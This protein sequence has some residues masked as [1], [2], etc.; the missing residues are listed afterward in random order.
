V[1]G[2]TGLGQ[3]YT[4][5]IDR[6]DYKITGLHP[7]FGALMGEKRETDSVMESA[8]CFNRLIVSRL[9]FLVCPMP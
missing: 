1:E 2:W 4:E 3:A 7:K 5:L 6:G 9:R 8:S